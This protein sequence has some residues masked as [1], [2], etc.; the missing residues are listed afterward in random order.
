MVKM[1]QAAIACIPRA[2]EGWGQWL[3][4]EKGRAGRGA[5]D[6]PGA[7]TEGPVGGSAGQGQ[8]QTQGQEGNLR[9]GR[10]LQRRGLL[11]HAHGQGQG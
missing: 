5:V 9:G 7:G 10:W 1:I 11:A 4:Q 8:G 6:G 3:G 2:G